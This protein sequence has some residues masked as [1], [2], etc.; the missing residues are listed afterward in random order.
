LIA[1][2]ISSICGEFNVS[3]EVQK[4]S[5][6]R[7]WVV[8]FAVVLAVIQYIDRVCISKSK[9]AIQTDLGLDDI[10]MGKVLSAFALA[11]ALF[12]IPSGWLGDRFGP[13]K[14]LI[15]VVLWWSFF[16]VATGWVGGLISLV[17]V[18]F[19][20]GAGE[21]GCFPNLTRAFVNWL[22]PNERVRAQSILWLCARWGGAVTPLIVY[23][24][25]QWFQSK[26]YP[27]PWRQSFYLFGGLGVIWTLV[28]AW[29][30]RDTPKE[31]AGVNAA[32][33]Q[34]LSTNSAYA[35]GH[36]GVPWGV[37]VRS[38][39]AWLLWIQ[40]FCQS[41]VWYFYVTW[42]PDYLTR[43]YHTTH[44]EK[45]LTKIAC[46]PLF[47]G[48][49][50]C[51]ISGFITKRVTALSGGLRRARQILAAFG[52]LGTSCGMAFLAFS[53]TTTLSPEAFGIA[54][55][56]ASL[57]GDFSMPCSWGA[58]MDVGG[59]FAGTFSG[60]MNM[61]GN[62]GGFVCPFLIGYAAKEG[63]WNLV[64]G[65]MAVAAFVGA[66]CWLKLDAVTP[67]DGS[68]ALIHSESFVPKDATAASIEEL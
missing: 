26:N 37:F 32:E 29:W 59:R 66:M 22:Q 13:K 48:G 19:L 8:V 68:A 5:R 18:R 27:Q 39:A 3:V 58:C 57:F 52:M 63:Q 53:N 30:F 50:G 17:A 67:L 34:L 14:A 43:H 16:T 40:Y 9:G 54:L 42:L 11:Y 36:G 31:H 55:G 23:E 49:I 24:V 62:F 1:H 4:P 10:G 21:A 45:Y 61:M 46:L 20:F 38:K 7:Y 15:R 2:L 12:E 44:D 28:F 25:L 51:L 65:S 60:T 41:Y 33:K 6:T 56:A 35:G 47:C 64:F